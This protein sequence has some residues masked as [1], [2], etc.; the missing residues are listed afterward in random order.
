VRALL[1]RG[2]QVRCLVRNESRRTNVEG[3]SVE[4]VFGDLRHPDSLSAA[5]RGIQTLYHCAADYRLYALDPGEIYRSNVEGTGNILAAAARC[6]VER[7]VYTSSVG[8]LG[9]RSDH[10]P[11]DETTPVALGAM[12]GHYKRSKFLAERVA[13]EWAAKGLPVVIVNPSTPIGERDVKPTPTGQMIVDFLNRKI[14]AYVDT[15]LNLI[16]VRDVALGHLLAA[17]RGRP[18]ERYILGHRNMTFRDILESLARITGLEAPKLRLP[19]WVPLAVSAFDT[20]RARLFRRVPRVPLEAVRMSRHR[21]F[22][23]ATKAVQALGLPQSPVEAALARAVRWFQVQGYV[24]P[25]RSR[26]S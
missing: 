5:L 13:E 10:E 3:L 21:M 23:N 19:H 17:E 15:G 24:R 14:P 18:G 25:P 9:R 20:A 7:I 16:D 12:I 8:A 26:R 1:E 6:G 4:I 22:F 11:A 2:R